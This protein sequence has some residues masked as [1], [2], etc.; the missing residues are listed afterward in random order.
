MSHN[1]FMFALFAAAT[2]PACGDLLKDANTHSNFLAPGI[3]GVYSTPLNNQRSGGD[4]A[5]GGDGYAYRVG[6]RDGTG[7]IGQSGIIPGTS[8]A[9]APPS[10]SYSYSGTY[11]LAKITSINIS[12]DSIYGFTSYDSGSLTLSA[13]FDGNTLS[14]RSGDLAVNGTIS[15]GDLS[16][17]V[18]YD[19]VSGAL[20]GMIGS[21]RSVGV[22][23]GNNAD[24][25][26][27]GGFIVD[28]D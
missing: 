18:T 22:F 26:F 3:T 12:G 13:D 2:L 25:I 23:H 7:L 9:A 10:G 5:S 15:N 8:V 11:E 28:V 21:D 14:G 19:G 16:G 27:A 4:V 17:G 1:K 6:A 24:T 20:D